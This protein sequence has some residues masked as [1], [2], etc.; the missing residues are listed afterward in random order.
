MIM[1]DIAR[2]SGELKKLR[3][4]H[5]ATALEDSKKWCVGPNTLVGNKPSDQ[6]WITIFDHGNPE[7]VGTDQ[8]HR[9]LVTFQLTRTVKW[10]K[11]GVAEAFNHFRSLELGDVNEAVARLAARLSGCMGE[12]QSIQTSAASKF[13]M[14]ARPLLPIFI[15]DQLATRSAKPRLP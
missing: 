10:D 13:A 6:Y 3:A 12:R 8:V 7:S 5:L 1:S 4:G 15:W 14:F 2:L 9:F 11:A